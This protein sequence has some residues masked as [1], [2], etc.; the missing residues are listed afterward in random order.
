MAALTAAALALTAANTVNTFV[1]QQRAAK[2]AQQQGNY[3]AGIYE[4]DAQIA[5]SQA[6]DA[7]ARGAETER[8]QRTL[9]GQTIGAQRAAMA[10]SGIDLGVG[11]A[12]DV[13]ADTAHIGELDALTIRNNA[14]REAYGYEVQAMDLR[15]RANLARVG[16]ANTAASL[17]N[18]SYGTLLS[19][20]LQTYSLG[21]DLAGEMKAS[22]YRKSLDTA[23]QFGRRYANTY[24]GGY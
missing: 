9:T 14:K 21:R 3:E 8:R 12:A 20:A 24:G 11:S 23:A 10:A 17:R 1:G 16:G 22:S 5:A 19:G 6:T 15:A 13:Q 2:G 4:Q 18:Q 7:V